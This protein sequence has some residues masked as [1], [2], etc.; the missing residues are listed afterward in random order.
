MQTDAGN[1]TAECVI[2]AAGMWGRDIA[3]MAGTRVP[4]CAVEHQYFVTE[5]TPRIADNLPTLRDPD[6]S[7]YVKPE[8]GALAVGGWETDPPPWGA[9]GIPLDFGP[10]LLQPDYDRFAPI[11]E[12]SG[13]RI[14]V[15]N[16]IGI[17]QMITG[18]IPIT[19]DGEPIIGLSPSSTISICA[20]DSPRA[21]RFRV[22]PAR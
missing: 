18:P 3:A 9:Q 4:V 6:G 11:A 21:S 2:D 10:E 13:A 15:L 22:A 12:A 16:E 5:K 20:A 19:A 1:V 8:P 14:P 17:R 7:F